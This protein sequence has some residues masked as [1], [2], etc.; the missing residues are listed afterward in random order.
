MI[1]NI[2]ILNILNFYVALVSSPISVATASWT[3][4]IWTFTTIVARDSSLARRRYATI[5]ISINPW[6]KKIAEEYEE[7][8]AKPSRC[9]WCSL[10]LLI[11]I[12]WACHLICMHTRTHFAFDF[13]SLRVMTRFLQNSPQNSRR[14]EEVKYKEEDIGYAHY[15]TEKHRK[16]LHSLPP[17]PRV[18]LIDTWKMFTKTAFACT[19]E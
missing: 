19:T 14:E 13:S 11:F 6:D 12:I 3:F 5:S 4:P 7:H 8:D 10:L 17:P 2:A 18:I 1:A 16:C 15:Y 9:E